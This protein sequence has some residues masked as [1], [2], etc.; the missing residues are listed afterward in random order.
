MFICVGA[1]LCDDY[2]Y[3]GTCN[4]VQA[5]IHA[6]TSAGNKSY[7]YEE[8]GSMVSDNDRTLSYTTFDKP[9]AITKGTHT[10]SFACGT[11]HNRYKRVDEEYSFNN[12][13]T[14]CG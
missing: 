13:Q 11:G 2:A 12:Y 8:N 3:G 4:G 7:C 10:T 5:G 9:S 6:V 1:I 14:L